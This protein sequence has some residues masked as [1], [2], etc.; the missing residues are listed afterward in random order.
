MQGEQDTKGQEDTSAFIKNVTKLALLHTT[1]GAASTQNTLMP[2]EMRVIDAQTGN[3]RLPT[4]PEAAAM[5]MLEFA[6]I[7]AVYTKTNGKYNEKALSKKLHEEGIWQDGHLNAIMTAFAVSGVLE[8]MGDIM[9]TN[10]SES[11]NAQQTGNLKYMITR[12]ENKTVAPISEPPALTLASASHAARAGS[13]QQAEAKLVADDEWM[14]AVNT[15]VDEHGH[16]LS[17][18]RKKELLR[19][20]EDELIPW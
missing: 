12:Y 18:E 1:P 19:M 8:S 7:D 15:G 20:A 16:D 4:M 2:K 10:T 13:P 6:R 11:M 9:M 3:E 14:R 5:V 17:E